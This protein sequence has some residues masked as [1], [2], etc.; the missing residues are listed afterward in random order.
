MKKS[1]KQIINSMKEIEILSQA[2]SNSI[3]KTKKSINE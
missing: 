1:E 2:I 3:L